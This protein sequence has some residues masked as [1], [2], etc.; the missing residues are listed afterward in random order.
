MVYLYYF[1][2]VFLDIYLL[3]CYME[4]LTFTMSKLGAGGDTLYFLCMQTLRPLHICNCMMSSAIIL[5]RTKHLVMHSSFPFP[6]YHYCY[7]LKATHAV[8]DS[9][10]ASSSCPTCIFIAMNDCVLCKM[11]FL[12]FFLAS[13]VIMNMGEL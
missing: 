12:K 8:Q 9:W 11:K 3:N 10:H 5:Y 6:M 1:C 2:S 13:T 7:T 4:L